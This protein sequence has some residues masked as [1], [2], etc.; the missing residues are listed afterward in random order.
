[1]INLSLGGPPDR[2]IGRLLEAAL[3]RGIDVVAAAD[4]A[5]AGGGFP[6]AVPGVVAVVDERVGAAPGGMVAAPGTRRAG[7]A[8][9]LALGGWSRARRTRRRTSAGCSP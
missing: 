6:A 9:R 4:R 5:P 3:A 8:A 1:M 7:A 2:L